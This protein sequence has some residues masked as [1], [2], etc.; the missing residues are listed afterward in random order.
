MKLVKNN[1][2]LDIG[3]VGLREGAD[4]G[5]PITRKDV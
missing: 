5:L 4:I 3:D 1:E 2:S